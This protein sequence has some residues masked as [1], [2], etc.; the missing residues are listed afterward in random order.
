MKSDPGNDIGLMY[1][2]RLSRDNNTQLN[3][4]RVEI[5]ILKPFASF[6]FRNT[7]TF[8][9]LFLLLS[10]V[11][12]Q[13]IYVYVYLSIVNFISFFCS[14]VSNIN[15]CLYV[16]LCLYYIFFVYTFTKVWTKCV[17]KRIQIK[18]KY[19]MNRSLAQKSKLYCTIGYGFNP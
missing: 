18:K 2:K 5:I 6:F 16:L 4:P 3:L 10:L 11:Q 12:W 17:Y 1:S 8:Y 19:G 15:Q 9:Y 13:C 14:S 7:E